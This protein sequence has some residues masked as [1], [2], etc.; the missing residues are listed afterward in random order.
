MSEIKVYRMTDYY[1]HSDD[2]GTPVVLFTDHE[3]AVKQAVAKERE[4]GRREEVT[5]LRSALT[6]VMQWVHTHPRKAT[7]VSSVI[8]EADD[9][10]AAVEVKIKETP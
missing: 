2:V 5:P 3:S 10:L 1:R 6:T 4:R 7:I 8:H 9:A